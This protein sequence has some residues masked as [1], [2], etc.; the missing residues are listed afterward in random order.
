MNISK[1][2]IDRPVLANVLAIVIVLIGLATSRYVIASRLGIDL[3][4]LNQMDPRV[5]RALHLDVIPD[6]VFAAMPLL[7]AWVRF[8]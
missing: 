4:M 7:I 6:L 1:F 5:L 2:F 3:G 8:K